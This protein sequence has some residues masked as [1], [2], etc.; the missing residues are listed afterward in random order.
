MSSG[1]GAWQRWRTAFS[2]SI[3]VRGDGATRR[4]IDATA[5]NGVCWGSHSALVA[6]VLHF[7]ELMAELEALGSGRNAYFTEDEEDAL[8]TR[9]RTTSDLLASHVPSSATR[10]PPDGAGE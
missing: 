4:Q 1:L 8:W 5:A 7:L 9:V 6:A 3:Y 10:Y 2:H